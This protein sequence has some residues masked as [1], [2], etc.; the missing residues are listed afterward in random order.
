MGKE[1]RSA[2]RERRRRLCPHRPMAPNRGKGSSEPADART[3]CILRKVAEAARYCPVR[4]RW[5]AGCP[6]FAGGRSRPTRPSAVPGG[7]GYA[8]VRQLRSRGFKSGGCSAS[9][10]DVLIHGGPTASARRDR[11]SGESHRD[12]L[13]V[14]RRKS[15]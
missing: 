12:V 13:V 3:L 7:G 14:L 10:V 11:I 9:A 8:S 2:H 6:A 1:N 15:R 4:E 5:R